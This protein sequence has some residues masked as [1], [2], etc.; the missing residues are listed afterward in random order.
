MTL[1]SKEPCDRPCGLQHMSLPC[2]G[3]KDATR[4]QI[5]V[6]KVWKDIASKAETVGVDYTQK[7]ADIFNSYPFKFLCE[8]L[9]Q[10]GKR[11][12]QLEE[13]LKK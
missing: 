9:D 13:Q 5:M 3:C 11:F 1:K 2:E 6:N 10:L 8:K 7:D 4:K 12:D